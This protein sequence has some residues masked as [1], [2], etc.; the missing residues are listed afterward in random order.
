MGEKR[1][2]P[3]LSSQGDGL[4]VRGCG[5]FDVRLVPTR[6]NVPL[7]ARGPCLVAALPPFACERDG[8]LGVSVC[9]VNRAGEKICLS[10][11]HVLERVGPHQL[12]RLPLRLS[13]LLQ[14][15]ALGDPPGE[16]ISVAEE[17]CRYR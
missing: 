17:T 16:R 13:L 6:G 12:E 4:A 9:V 8:P 11:M 2:H 10:A 15:Q 1:P 5:T 7:E 3:Q 14:G